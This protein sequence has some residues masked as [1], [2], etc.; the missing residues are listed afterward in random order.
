[1]KFIFLGSGTFGLPAL[2]ALAKSSHRAAA[3]VTSADKPAG[4]GLRVAESPIKA[5]ARSL[6]LP[7]IELENPNSSESIGRALELG[8]ECV[9]AVSYGVI[10]KK[11]FLTAFPKGC[12]NL[13]ASLLPRHRGASPVASALLAGDAETGVTTQLMAERLDA[14]DILLQDKLALKGSENAEEVTQRLSEMG[15]DLVVKTLDQIAAGKAQGQPQDETK[16]TYAPKLSKEDGRID[17]SRS[18]QEIHNQ[19]RAFYIWPGSRAAW[20]GKE[21]TILQTSVA[22]D[23]PLEAGTV[24]GPSPEGIR[25]ACG[26][27]TLVIERLQ[28]EGRKAMSFKD[29]LNGNRLEP[30]TVL[31]RAN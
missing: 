31:G 16:V 5:H 17:W 11:H 1:M 22:G 9:V 14:G 3:V 15:G 13:H 30:G 25:V 20:N 4:R 10:F 28:L 8:A 19:V 21:I 18:A 12:I 27:G 24:I 2:S 7:L 23:A 6:G 29:F 26:K